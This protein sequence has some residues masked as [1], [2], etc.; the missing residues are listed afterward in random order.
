[1]P[2]RALEAERQPQSEPRLRQSDEGAAETVEAATAILLE[3]LLESVNRRGQTA[4]RR[5]RKHDAR[6][7]HGVKAI[8]NPADLRWSLALSRHRPLQAF[9]DSSRALA[10]RR[11]G[12][13]SAGAIWGALSG[14][15]NRCMLLFPQFDWCGFVDRKPHP[16]QIEKR[17]PH[18]AGGTDAFHV[19]DQRDERCI[20]GAVSRGLAGFDERNHASRC[21]F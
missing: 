19:V 6:Y 1:M 2:A 14:R 21:C 17:V 9:A 18:F 4:S 16:V 12:T 20:C 7:G 15:A 3:V 13:A 11:S 10:W 8:A 5:T